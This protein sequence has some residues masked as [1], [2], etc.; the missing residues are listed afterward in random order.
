MDT[1]LVL[2]DIDFWQGII[3]NS[4][5]LPKGSSPSE[6]AA[7]LLPYLALPD[8][9]LRDKVAYSVLARWIILYRYYSG[10]ELRAM[11]EWLL[12][13]L[14]PPS[15]DDEDDSIF[16]RSSAAS[17]LA[18]IV[19]RHNIQPFLNEAEMMTLLDRARYYLVTEPDTR[20]YIPEKGFAA[21]CSHTADLLKFLASSTYL[22]ARD[23]Q[24][25]IE[26]IA[27]KLMLPTTYIFTHDEDERLAKVIM[28]ILRRNDLAP[29]DVQNWLRR[30]GNWKDAHPVPDE[31]NPVY[32][33]TH[34]NVK[35]FLKSLFCQMQIANPPLP[36]DVQPLEGDI[37]YLLGLY[38]L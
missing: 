13:H 18:L 27:D 23:L 34:Q 29:E 22:Q 21:A 19:Y 5:R 10:D 3:G 8:D 1:E 35:L 14:S 11:M 15:N 33:A 38:S 6:L 36:L 32:H 17:V 4:Y 37:L 25:L 7:E 20:A 28:V 31:H 26:A 30:F 12:P 2:H 24:R 16:I 9:Y